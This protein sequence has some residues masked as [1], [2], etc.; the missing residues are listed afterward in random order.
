MINLTKTNEIPQCGGI[1]GESTMKNASEN[2]FR[3]ALASGRRLIG[4]HVNLT[5]YRICEILGQAGFDYLWI[6]ME[7]VGTSFADMERHLIAA[8]A[9]GTP[10]LV[11]V[12]WNEIPQIKRVL[13][14][15]PD[16]IVVPMVNS[17]E[18]AR[19]AI[20][21]CIY[22]P[23]G[24]RGFGPCRAVRYGMDSARDYIDRISKQLCR[25]V[26]IESEDAVNA[27]DGMAEIPYLDGF[28]LGP[29]DLSG[30]VHE[31]GHIMDG[32]ETTRLIALAVEKAH[33]AGKPIGLSVG[34]T[35]PAELQFWL[36][37]G[38]DFI[39]AGSDVGSILNGALTLA[40][41]LR[42][43]TESKAD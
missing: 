28:I 23:E 43:L 21:T 19:Q 40:A 41:D 14:A 33:R 42:R 24:K 25:F 38:V 4:T 39:S 16:A 12:P 11:R 32:K 37:K 2:A 30:S 27:M 1:K 35:N 6:D 17:V 26:Q 29:M 20:D 13:E 18:E 22:P 3:Q 15:G 8:K 34:T 10:C 36:D 7:H 31:L 9:A 5:D